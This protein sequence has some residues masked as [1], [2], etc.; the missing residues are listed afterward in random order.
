MFLFIIRIPRK[1]T[2][3]KLYKNSFSTSSLT[4]EIGIDWLRMD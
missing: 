1:L 3:I 4:Y 2:V